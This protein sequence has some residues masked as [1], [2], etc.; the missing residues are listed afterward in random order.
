[1]KIPLHPS[2]QHSAEEPWRASSQ[3]APL[4]G[5]GTVQL[6]TAIPRRRQW[7]QQKRSQVSLAL[8]YTDIDTDRC[9]RQATD[10][11]TDP[12]HHLFAL[13]PSGRT[14]R[15]IRAKDLPDCSSP[16]PSEFCAL[17]ECCPP[18]PSPSPFPSPTPCDDDYTHA[19]KCTST[20]DVDRLFSTV[21]WT[22]CISTFF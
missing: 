10:T 6:P 11:T 15:S 20:L 1:M 14:L 2:W 21:H 13:L 8:P 18:A 17:S 5:A 9:V 16:K 4:S 22:K 19:Y 12:S 7:E 3:T